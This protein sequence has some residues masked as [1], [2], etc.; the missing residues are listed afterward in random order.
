MEPHPP[1]DEDNVSIWSA[2]G[3]FLMKPREFAE[4][5]QMITYRSELPQQKT[6]KKPTGNLG[7]MSFGG[8]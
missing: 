1:S 5:D 3:K 4:Q 8:L 2:A 7:Q 6:Q